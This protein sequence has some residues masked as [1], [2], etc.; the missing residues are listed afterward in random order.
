MKDKIIAY[1]KD[2]GV[3]YESF[4]RYA[5]TDTRYIAL[6]DDNERKTIVHIALNFKGYR[7]YNANRRVK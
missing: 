6:L 5:E 3:D 1:L 4:I 7:A 2:L